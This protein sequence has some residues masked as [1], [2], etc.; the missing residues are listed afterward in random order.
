MK[1]NSKDVQALY[2]AIYWASA[3]RTDVESLASGSTLVSP[4]QYHQ[5]L[6]R[7]LGELD[8]CIEGVLLGTNRCRKGQ[9]NRTIQDRPKIT[10]LPRN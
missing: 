10:V 5:N 7:C 3:I 4:E 9:D 8:Q 6:I 2:E 1:L